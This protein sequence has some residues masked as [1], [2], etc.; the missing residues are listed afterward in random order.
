MRIERLA[1]NKVKVTL[2]GDD[3][4]GYDI[5]VK[6]LS[7]NSTELHSFLFK[8]METIHEETG[9]NP[10]NGQIVV[11]ARSAGDGISIII[12]KICKGERQTVETVIKGHRVRARIREEGINTYYF[13]SFDDMCEALVNLNNEVH[14]CGSLYKLDGVYCYLLDCSNPFFRS[15]SELYAAVS[16]LAEF[17][18][19]NS[20]FPMQ[21]IHVEEHGTLIAEGESLIAMA[22]GIKKS[23]S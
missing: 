12:S 4:I 5:N 20:V 3:L 18:S 13:E 17:S 1:E 21:H 7:H 23:L 19:G 16:V 15:K 10:Y 9:F 2:T 6:N 8:I 11:E 14:R 22:D